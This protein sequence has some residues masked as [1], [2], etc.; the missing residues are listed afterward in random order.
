MPK[1]LV[2][3][4]L[5]LVA[6]PIL[7]ADE[8]M[9]DYTKVQACEILKRHMATIEQLPGRRP[10]PEWYCDFWDS[11]SDKYFYVVALW[12]GPI[13][14]LGIDHPQSAGHFAVAK[15][16]DIV[17]EFDLLNERL[18]PISKEYYGPSPPKG[19]AKAPAGK[20]H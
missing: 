6:L 4:A 11:Y 5:L 18:V 16:S 14:R 19:G 20:S 7:A 17:L 9:V 2:A 3:L 1:S 8:E 12:T 10:L 15:R 13:A